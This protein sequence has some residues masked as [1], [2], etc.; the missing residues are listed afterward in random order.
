[1]SELLER[2]RRVLGEGPPLRLALLF[3]SATRGTLRPES[4]VDVAVLPADA[5]LTLADELALQ[6]RLSKAAQREVDLVRLDR[7]SSLLR[8]RVARE[9]VELVA[10]PP[11]ELSRFRA[12]AAIEHAD[13]LP[14]LQ[15]A[16]E[17]VRRRLVEGKGR[18]PGA[19]Q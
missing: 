10:N 17:I 7:A 6:A 11:F 4:D 3:G 12:A 9:G 8:W 13:M 19:E 5:A 18:T 15:H 14:Q 16:Q 1:M 2:L